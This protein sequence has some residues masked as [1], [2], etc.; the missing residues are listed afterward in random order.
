MEQLEKT[1]A[2]AEEYQALS[3]EERPTVVPGGIALGDPQNNA[4]EGFRTGKTRWNKRG[5]SW[6][7]IARSLRPS[8]AH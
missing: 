5:D 8:V 1:L 4:V 6:P 7:I 3:D 2:V